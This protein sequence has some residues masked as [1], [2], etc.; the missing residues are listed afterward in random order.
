MRFKQWK[1]N[2]SSRKKFISYFTKF[3]ATST[4]TGFKAILISNVA[5]SCL[6]MNFSSNACVRYLKNQREKSKNLSSLL[7][8]GKYWFGN[9]TMIRKFWIKGKI[10]RFRNFPSTV[11]ISHTSINLHW[12]NA[13][14]PTRLRQI[15]QRHATK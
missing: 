14:N 11:C 5:K 10:Q 13:I 2:K 15:G 3:Q 1:F 12:R 6:R 4:P 9:S 7:K 8:L